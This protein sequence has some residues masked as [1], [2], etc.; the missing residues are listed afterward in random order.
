[1]LL[2]LSIISH[3]SASLG[4]NSYKMFDERG[5]TIGRADN[6]FWVLPDPEKSVSRTHAAVRMIAGSFF[7]EDLSV[8][9]IFLRSTGEQIGRGEP[10]LLRDGDR[11]VMGDY[12]LMAQ[13]LAGAASQP[14]AQAPPPPAA[15][16][17]PPAVSQQPAAHA[18]PAPPGQQSAAAGGWPAGPSASYGGTPDMGGVAAQPAYATRAPEDLDPLR[19]LGTPT[20]RTGPKPTGPGE[21]YSDLRDRSPMEGHYQPPDVRFPGG[22]APS[23]PSGAEG[24]LTAFGHRP[25]AAPAAPAWQQA[26]PPPSAPQAGYGQDVWPTQQGGWPGAG[27]AAAPPPADE[28]H[29]LTMFGHR[30]GAPAAAPTQQP[31][32]YA[33][34]PPPAYAP[35]PPAAPFGAQP[36]AYGAPPP[37]AATPGFGQGAGAAPAPAWPVHADPWGAPQPEPQPQGGGFGPAAMPAPP[38][39]PAQTAWGSP[40]VPPPPP[41]QAPPPQPAWGMAPP[42]P[43]VQAPPS[44]GPSLAEM[45]A[46]AGLDPSRVSPEV[47]AQIGHILRTVVQGLVGVLQARAQVKGTFRLPMTMIQPVEN[48][49]LKFSANFEDAMQNLF[50]KRT[51]GWLGPTDSFQDAFDD[52]TAHEMAMV[53][54]I[55]AAFAAMLEKFSPATLE[56]QYERKAKRGGIFGGGKAAYWDLYRESFEELSSDSEGNFQ[57]LFGEDFAK[58]YHE[59]M[60]R[61]I[62]AQKNQRRRN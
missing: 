41:P 61:L 34:P 17:W 1:M 55:R 45:F 35:P 10:Y 8:N 13:V 5:G 22:Q 14:G 20:G 16:A 54:G 19:A 48:N 56:S 58:A 18:W 7:L 52:L 49:P 4:P 40:P 47:Y 30:P 9:G 12:E 11:I 38:P 29:A 24:E 37:P 42:A 62:A 23:A 26:A 32:A 36:A 28:E 59:Q 44:G 15:E 60:Q 2:T 57:R 51:Q 46:N 43:Q 25:G 33:P 27:Q 6:N 53:A 3:Q 31:P 21:S 50:L 39:A